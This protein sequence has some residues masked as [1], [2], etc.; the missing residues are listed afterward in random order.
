MDQRGLTYQV[1]ALEEKPTASA[2]RGLA[3]GS[4]R[5]LTANDSGA[6]VLLDTAAGST[7]VLPAGSTCAVGT[8]FQF[9]VTTVATSN[10][11]IIRVANA[12][13]IMVGVI[14]TLDTT[15]GALAPFGT[16]AASDTITLN[17]STTGSVRTGETIYA[18]YVATNRWLIE[19]TVVISGVAATPF[20]A[21]V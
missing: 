20:S 3:A 1:A 10:N 11:H 12:S 5:T 2:N 19:G 14:E 15:T 13:D 8:N 21:T 4:S 18:T 17:R 7:V 6:I 9:V 16:A